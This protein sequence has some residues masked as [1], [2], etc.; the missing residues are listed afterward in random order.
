MEREIGGVRGIWRISPGTNFVFVLLSGIGL[1]L[2][3]LVYHGRTLVQM[4]KGILVV[5]YWISTVFKATRTKGETFGWRI[6]ASCCNCAMAL[7]DAVNWP[8]PSAVVCELF[9]L[10]KYWKE[11]DTKQFVFIPLSILFIFIQVMRSRGPTLYF[12]FQCNNL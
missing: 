3:V 2:P 4:P 12:L 10:F 9:L 6:S 8:V 7:E 1:L 11:Y 5:V